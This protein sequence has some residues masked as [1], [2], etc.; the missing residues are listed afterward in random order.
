MTTR[1]PCLFKILNVTK[2]SL[3]KLANTLKFRES[4]W[5]GKAAKPCHT[6]SLISLMTQ[7][8]HHIV[9]SYDSEQQMWFLSETSGECLWQWVWQSVWRAVPQRKK[10][11]PW[12]KKLVLEWQLICSRQRILQLEKK[13]VFHETTIN[14]W[15]NELLQI[16][17]EYLV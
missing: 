17:G 12:R 15:T 6:W 10:F 8:H 2:H 14:P 11:L 7:K 4:N 1:K 5:H 3:Q 9:W 13:N 16:Y